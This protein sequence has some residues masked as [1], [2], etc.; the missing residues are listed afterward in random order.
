MIGDVGPVRSPVLVQAVAVL[1]IL[2]LPLGLFFAWGKVNNE[3]SYKYEAQGPDF[4]E[5]S[6][7]GSW[8]ENF[9]RIMDNIEFHRKVAQRLRIT[10]MGPKA[11]ERTMADARITDIEDGFQYFSAL[12]DGC[13]CIV[14]Y[15]RRDWAFAGIEVLSPEDFLLNCVV[16]H[17]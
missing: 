1:V 15:D 8:T 3:I 6:A 2:C 12:D 13:T 10:S 17:R 11:V 7:F 9:R 14:T 4:Q 5:K 16:K